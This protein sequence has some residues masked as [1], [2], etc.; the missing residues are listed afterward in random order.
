MADDYDY[1]P[2]YYHVQRKQEDAAQ[3]LRQRQLNDQQQFTR[4]ANRKDYVVQTGAVGTKKQFIQPTPSMQDVQR[5][6]V[7]EQITRNPSLLKRAIMP[8][9]PTPMKAVPQP[10]AVST[11]PYIPQVKKPMQKTPS[12]LFITGMQGATPVKK[13]PTSFKKVYHKPTSD[14]LLLK[15]LRN[16]DSMSNAVL[17]KPREKR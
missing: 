10:R 9:M 2:D 3:A 1:G 6:P 7:G 14:E 5:M 16:L 11:Q 12:M 13:W 17:G 8:T 4:L 15:G